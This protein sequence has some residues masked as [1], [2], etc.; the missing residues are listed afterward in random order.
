MSRSSTATCL[1]MPD[2]ATASRRTSGSARK[3]QGATDQ[4]DEQL[5][6]RFE[7]ENLVMKSVQIPHDKRYDRM[8]YYRMCGGTADETGHFARIVQTNRRMHGLVEEKKQVCLEAG[9][10]DIAEREVEDETCDGE[11]IA[12][13]PAACLA[14]RVEWQESFN[15]QVRRLFV[16]FELT[17]SPGCRLN[18]LDRM[19]AWFTEHGAKQTRKVQ[20]GPNYLVADRKGP[21]LPGSTRN[22]ITSLKR[23]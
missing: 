21:A 9:F 11:R 4:K 16:D 6:G 22:I 5:V 10:E 3:R 14:E 7:D 20:K 13:N 23:P 2:I 17:Q 19:S 8:D 12:R 15:Q 18:H 1:T